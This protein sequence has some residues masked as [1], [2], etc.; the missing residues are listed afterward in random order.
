MNK[1]ALK[2]FAIEARQELHEKIQLQ[3]LKLGI[4]PDAIQQAS[5]ESSD[6]IF[7]DGN[8][9]SDVERQQRNKLIARIEE[10]GY[11]RVIEEAAYTW[12][13]RFIA[14]RYMEVN[15]YLPTKVRVLSSVNPDSTEPDMFKEAINLDLQ[16]DKE[17]VYNLK[18]ENKTE[19][20]FKYLIKIHCNDLNKYMPFMFE[21]IEGYME[22]LFPEG[23]LSSGSFIRKMTNLDIIKE[24][25]WFN[26][27]IVGWIYQFY[28]TEINEIVYDGS[29]SKSRITK[30]LLP[31]ATQLF[32]PDWAVKYMI[33]N[34]LGRFW[35]ETT[36]DETLINDWK[37][38][39]KGDIEQNVSI[40][41]LN[42]SIEEIKLIDPCM[43]SGHMLVYAF[44]VFMQIYQSQGYV[45]RDAAKLILENNLYGIDI[46]DRAY[47]LAS[48]SLMMK[49]RKY[50]RR[51][52]TENIT[53]NLCSVKE[54][55]TL[56][57]EDVEMLSEIIPDK[58]PI[59]VEFLNT[60]IKAKEYGSILN[61]NG[62]EYSD[63][64]S[65][66]EDI[67]ENL[68]LNLFTNNTL[69]AI[70]NVLPDLIK[71]SDIMS[72]KYEIVVTNPPY[73]SNS[74]MS[75]LLDQYV[76]EF[77][78][79]SK[80]D[81]AMV[82]FEKSMKDFLEKDGYISFITTNSWMTLKS[83]LNIRKKVINEMQ[84]ISLV[85]FG[86]ELFDGKVGHNPIVSWVNKNVAP[87]HEFTA[88]D[89]TEFCYSKRNEK[90]QEFFNVNNRFY[91]N[92]TN[93]SKISGVPVAYWLTEQFNQIFDEGVPLGE[94]GK[95]SEGVKTGK[96]ELYLRYWYEVNP[97]KFSFGKSKKDFKWYP[98]HKGGE[99]RK[100]YGNLEWAINWENDGA[101]IKNSPNSGL[102][103]K[104]MYFQ[105]I[106]SWSKITS[107]GISLRYI[108]E[109]FLFDSG[110][111][112]FKSEDNL[113]YYLGF[114]N[115]VVGEFLLGKLNPTMNLQVGDVKS[116]PIM[117]DKTKQ[118]LIE[119][120]V[121]K[122]IAL[123]KE[124][125]DLNEISWEFKNSPLVKGYSN[126]KEA[127]DAYIKYTEEKFE[128]LKSNE[129]AINKTFLDIYGLGNVLSYK[130]NDNNIKISRANFS[131]DI[132]RFI[133]YGIGCIF[134]RY[135]IEK[136]GLVNE[137]R[138]CILP[139][140]SKL[141][142]N[143]DLLSKFLKF[144]IEVFS[145]D[146]LDVNLSFIADALGKKVNESARETLQRYFVT[147]FYKD[148]LQLYQK[149]PI[150]WLFTSGK[151]K[152]FNCLIYMNSYDKTI[153]SRIRT[154]YVHEV[155]NRMD[156][157]KVDLLNII[158]GDSTVKEIATAKK[159]LKSLEKKI[160]EL[161]KYDEVLH[162]MADQ[163]IEIDLDKGVNHNYQLFKGL[164]A[165]IK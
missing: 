78:P 102:Q 57:L 17:L 41:Q 38:Y 87:T 44:E 119:D 131:K 116:L 124:D 96:N 7:I 86:T 163:Q 58:Y 24:K 151:E 81:L 53:L 66:L 82:M 36:K 160:D 35:L 157:E 1:S 113:F 153:L 138:E 56:K 106:L 143:D 73:L 137:K 22:V 48:F 130:V 15:D 29:M 13:N 158:N 135:S 5:L 98:Y 67:K 156:A 121:G 122:N 101:E 155:Q 99:Y 147:D 50:N 141:Y 72:Q 144:L 16:I 142:F 84:F 165:P 125:W 2:S 159:E 40:P 34:T 85:D 145:E 33:E 28:N 4:T 11:D 132:K 32:T 9:L 19:E 51:I 69:D 93:F 112:A 68:E 92:Q 149:R 90:E 120:L 97:L 161:K 148:H 12:F 109:N 111:P 37:Y 31:A 100:W 162:H 133:S 95:S 25:D 3:A 127:Y 64:K 42:K 77:Y 45:A 49:A 43:G 30:D 39:L 115:S 61:L 129:E 8:P 62:I 46:D 140:L 10:I 76:K 79:N 80:N 54:S 164:V 83:F 118:N 123:T 104:D 126:I 146:T 105:E 70:N 88:I 89:L 14:L 59:L 65:I 18:I 21:T 26:V 134:G 52:F 20:L 71:Q 108:P 23:L 47:Q 94:L 154:D 103:G 63:L 114:I 107:K 91:P 75:N 27:E 74:R 60:F 110:S 128:E 6:A 117:F 136:E 152:A 139:V 55:D 150:Y